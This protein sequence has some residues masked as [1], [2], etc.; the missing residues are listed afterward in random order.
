MITTFLASARDRERLASLKTASVSSPRTPAGVGV[1]GRASPQGDRLNDKL[2][3]A[4][5]GSGN[6][7]TDLL[8]KVRRSPALTCTLFIGRRADSRGMQ[9][10]REAGVPVS[11]QSINAIVQQPD[12]CELVFDATSAEDHMRHWPVLAELGKM[13]IDMTPS[14]IGRMVIPA[15]DFDQPIPHQNVNMVSCGGQAAIPLAH[16]VAK[17]H[18]DIE[19]IEVVSSIASKS[20]GP[21]TRINLDEYIETTEDALRAYTRC[22]K[23]KTIL[24][25][26]PAEP[27]IDMQVTV[28]AKVKT[29]HLERLNVLLKDLVARIQAYVP[30]Y[31][32]IVPPVFQTNRIFMMARV[33][34]RGDYLPAY[35]GN[36]DIINCAA[37]AT[38]EK[39][40]AQKH[41]SP[42][43][44]DA[45]RS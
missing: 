4:I 31:A 16:L 1:R 27:C 19:Y 34:G 13:V 14:K 24:I 18:D 42:A 23:T 33:R 40:A 44:M 37:V 38:A 6:I 35:A 41:A 5:L 11:N 32:V 3:V 22:A 25:L 8:M 28:S 45:I 39:F 15:V 9:V 36:L 12:C 30:G 17:T 7:G 20:A 26:N 2:N 43:A 21:A 10:A 29:P